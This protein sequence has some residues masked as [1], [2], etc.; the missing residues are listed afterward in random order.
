MYDVCIYDLLV[1]CFSSY[2]KSFILKHFSKLRKN[3]KE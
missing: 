3:S 2:E 1:R